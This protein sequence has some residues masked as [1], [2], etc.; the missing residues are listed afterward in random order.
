MFS[1]L[2]LWPFTVLVMGHGI[3]TPATSLQIVDYLYYGPNDYKPVIA[4][5]TMSARVLGFKNPTAGREL[6]N[7][8]N[9]G[10]VYAM[11]QFQKASPCCQ[12]CF[13]VVDV[14]PRFRT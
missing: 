9:R 3:V 6:A 2:Q 10:S 5:R 4:V 7:V 14:S 11:I 8:Y 13:L 12:C 1:A